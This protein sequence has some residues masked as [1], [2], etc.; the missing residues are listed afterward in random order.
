MIKTLNKVGI[1][2]IYLKI[3]KPVYDK[4]IDNIRN[5]ENLEVLP[6]RS[7]IWMPALTTC[8]QH[9]AGSPTQSN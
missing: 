5:G 9:S 8:I 1:E 6:K 2:G 3:I 4:P 7:G